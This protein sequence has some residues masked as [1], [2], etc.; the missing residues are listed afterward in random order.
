MSQ[1]AFVQEKHRAMAS[2]VIQN[3]GKLEETATRVLSFSKTSTK[4][5]PTTQSLQM[6]LQVSMEKGI[7]VGMD[8]L[9]ASMITITASINRG[10]SYTPRKSTSSTDQVRATIRI[11]LQSSRRVLVV[12]QKTKIDVPYTATLVTKYYGTGRT[13]QKQVEGVFTSV[14]F[15][16]IH[17]DYEKSISLP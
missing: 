16:S 15:S 8:V 7:T 2:I 10:F 5:I 13:R 12:V 11:P 3:R 6:G 9:S 1:A 14:D 4:S 17:T